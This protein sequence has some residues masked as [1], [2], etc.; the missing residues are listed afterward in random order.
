MR[1][2]L[3]KDIRNIKAGEYAYDKKPNGDLDEIY[4]CCPFNDNELFWLNDR[5]K[6]EVNDG[7]LTIHGSIWCDCPHHFNVK[8]G[9]VI[10]IR[11][12]GKRLNTETGEVS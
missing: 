11:D 9:V 4:I 5:H 8:D 2:T 10:L 3:T 1:C 12:D 6:V 7:N